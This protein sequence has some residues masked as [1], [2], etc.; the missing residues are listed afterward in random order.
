MSVLL[1]F[2]RAGLIETN[3]RSLTILDLPGLP[4]SPICDNFRWRRCAT[5]RNH[6][7]I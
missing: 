1:A 2:R 4:A 5:S 3:E 7:R 6:G